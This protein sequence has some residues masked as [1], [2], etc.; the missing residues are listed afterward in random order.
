MYGMRGKFN[1]FTYYFVLTF[2]VLV[3]VCQYFAVMRVKAATIRYANYST[4][5]DAN[6]CTVDAPCK[7][8][9]RAYA[10]AVSGD[11]I[12]LTGTFDWSNADE[13]G[14]ATT[15]GFTLNKTLI[16]QGHGADQTIIQAASSANT[17]GKRIFTAG[18]LTLIG[19]TIRYG[20]INNS[21][22]P[23]AITAGA[24][25]IL[26]C[27]IDQNKNHYNRYV[28]GA[29]YT[30]GNMTMR[31]STMSNNENGYAGG[32]YLGGSTNEIT[33]STF[34][35]NVG[36]Y[37]GAVYL[38][39]QNLS[40]TVTS[41]T[42]LNNK[43]N[44]G[45]GADLDAY[46]SGGKL[47]LKNSILAQ[48]QGGYNLV[49]EN[50]S[51]VVDGGYNIVEYQNGGG[52]T[53]GVNGNLVGVQAN[54]NIAGSLAMND[55]T[56][57]VP[58]LAL[59][60]G[61][62]A[63]NAGDPNDTAN[64]SINVP[65]ADQRN[66]YRSGITDIGAYE[67]SGSSSYSRPDTQASSIT[68]STIG[69]NQMT[70]SW[71]NG[72][73][74]R[75][76]VFMKAA[77]SGTAS[78]ADNTTYTASTTFGSGTQIDSTGW[79][80]VYNGAGTS[81]TVTGLTRSTD[82]IV[83]TF[84]YSGIPGS[85][86][87]FTDTA[88]EN[89][90]VQATTA[91]PEP[92]TQASNLT[93]SNLAYTSM[94][95]SWTNGDGSKRIVFA[96]QAN[97]GTALPVDDTT[98]TAN[99]SFGSGTQ[100]S[101]SGW[102]CIYNGTGTSVSVSNL[103]A[104]TDYI[105]QVFE[106]NGTAGIENYF[107][108]TATDNPKVQASATVTE[109]TT[110]ASN[111]TFSSV[112]YTT[113]T[114]SWTN[115]NSSSSRRVVF[116]K[117]AN[118]GTATPV[119]N[120]NYS[121]STTFGSGTQIGTS[122]WYCVYNSSST[123][124]SVS[125]LIAQ[126]DYI[127]Q[128][129]EYNYSGSVYN[130][131]ANSGTNNP[132]VQATATVLAPTTQATNLT[133]ASVSYTTMT[134]SW[135]NGNGGKR[136][137]FAKQAN[138]GTAAPVD[139]ASYTANTAFGSGTQI[140]SSGW[141]CIYNST[142]TSVAVTAL[143][144]N[145]EYIFHVVEYNESGSVRTY[146]VASATNN[147][148]SQAT[149]AVSEPT[150]QAY[151]ITYSSVSSTG[152]T[153]GW[154]NGNGEK[155]VVFAKLANSGT[156]SPVD[157]TTYTASTTFGSGTQIGSSG[158]YCV[159][160]STGT[161][162][163]ITGLSASSTYI[164]QTFEYNGVAGAENYFLD[165]ATDNPKTQITSAAPSEVSLGTGTSTT[166]ISEASPINIWYQSLHGQSVYTA[167]EINAAGM[168]G[169]VEITKIGFYIASAPVRALPNFVIRMKHTSDTTV[170]NWQSVTGM[171]TVYS[172]AS[173]TPTAGGFDSLTLSTPFTWNGTDNIV[174]DTAFSIVSFSQSGT[175]R[176]Y[177]SS[178]GYRYAR[179][180]GSDQTNVFSGGS[181]SSSKPQIKLT[182]NVNYTLTYS[183]SAHGSISGSTPQTVASGGNGTEVTAVPDAGYHFV[184]WDDG[185]LTA[186]RTDT[187]IISNHTHTA[188]FAI[189]TYSLTYTSGSHG[190]ISGSSPQTV[191]YGANGTAVEAV[192][193]TGYHFTSWSDLLGDNPR[194]D[195]NVTDNV[196]VTA[197]FE[198]N[199][200]S[201][202]Y[203]A[204]A[205]GPGNAVN[206]TIEGSSSQSVNYGSNGTAVTAIPNTGYY[207]VRWSDNVTS[208]PRTDSNIS[209]SL[210]VYAIFDISTYFLTYSAGAGG[211]ILGSSSQTIEYGNNGSSV[212]AIPES[213]CRFARWSDGSTDNPRQDLSITGNISVSAVF[214]FIPTSGEPSTPSSESSV[215]SGGQLSSNQNTV[216]KT[217]N[218]I[219]NALN[220]P[221]PPSTP[222]VFKGSWKLITSPALSS[223][224]FAP[225]PQNLQNL[226]VKFSSF[227]LALKNLDVKGLS[228]VG[229]LIGQNLPLASL[230]KTLDL[231]APSSLDSLTSKEKEKIP[232]EIV[233]VQNESQNIDFNINVSLED[234]AN[235]KQI[236]STIAG[237]E[238]TLITKPEDRVKSV[239]GKLIY[240]SSAPEISKGK[241]FKLSG[242]HAKSAF[243]EEQSVK[244]VTETFD[245]SDDDKDGIYTSQIS[246]PG[247]AG[248]YEIVTSFDYSDNS[249]GKKDISMV[250]VV[251][252]EGYIFEKINGQEARILGATA[253]L[254]WKN[255][256]TKNFE[257][258]P[259]EKFSQ[260]N[261]Q[262]T[263]K[264]GEYSFLVPDG[265]YKLEVKAL[266]YKDYQSDVMV[267]S[268]NRGISLNVEMLTK[269]PLKR[270][271]QNYFFGTIIFLLLIA[272][273]ILLY[274]KNIKYRRMR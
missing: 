143:V 240:Q 13:T 156:A 230:S 266:G 105:F 241:T 2:F 227:N 183:A 212:T 200:Y 235:P 214:E 187:D 99:T 29:I 267:I 63:I 174:V 125:N 166:G 258:W 38:T 109:P 65:V 86:L 66:F 4:G 140:D 74:Q 252:P 17:A 186:S 60:E 73:G 248:E 47:Y 251:D 269:N 220:V 253:T 260:T 246:S 26:N 117:Q 138:S 59:S 239:T 150:A 261:P 39:S 115:G 191:N 164:F 134:V 196:S 45:Y 169:P 173:Y 120:T 20:F 3:L 179:S 203:S 88:T 215:S 255:P 272:I 30:G 108:D 114:V 56:N 113:M 10:V 245:Y 23:S 16:I 130:Y 236:V 7:T 224:V 274:K 205:P 91:V 148:K 72:N 202:H 197:S 49:A 152:M 55:T 176:Y 122:G 18:N 223:F 208:N 199:S 77:N 46:G 132:L 149:A 219:N 257:N 163:T 139:N 158:W 97:S 64:N 78:P 87:Y 188:S 185:V 232:T 48:R 129:F 85:E 71:T 121:A 41:S 161:S 195:S 177:S 193:D 198:I 146:N 68:F 50:G 136:A 181:T 83:Q 263:G 256:E 231:P 28:N 184:S 222:P 154:S 69:Y 43:S 42:F 57:G 217:V 133:F 233:F 124:V 225:L 141:Y 243:A 14:D 58:T 21:E 207:F 168:S 201:L 211:S 36:D 155:R 22:A 62:V 106:Y 33:N 118:S 61:S 145:T 157:N 159:Y 180:D 89:P 95:V 165:S 8:F 75:R 204:S 162:V 237:K 234:P 126:T 100:I 6:G 175:V 264:T 82:Y 25:T 12:D 153:V 101:S 238:L 32:F 189:N 76:A 116:A 127:F 265:E 54:L 5:D 178:N 19:L 103:V 137:V 102:Y 209:S 144:P 34:F 244:L 250:A 110:Q 171:T 92:A 221:N 111:I 79:Y 271:P 40:L 259:A 11:T 226:A 37:Y 35:N 135:S 84:E 170:A 80:C 98:Y 51:I 70:T 247:Q 229:K 206:G 254:L 90:K 44:Y 190:S 27:V 123:S 167:A 172:N 107:T 112:N 262:I 192:P 1:K 160:N 15:S 228:D 52:L 216:S 270:I 147:P 131:N 151:T 182:F 194:T 119:D 31:N 210:T 249:A 104:Q 53:N 96:K 24:L 67:F 273:S 268:Q 218:D 93:F 142:G 242:L 9:T 94:T 213:G 128:V 81:V